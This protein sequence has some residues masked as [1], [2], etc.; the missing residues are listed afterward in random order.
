MKPHEPVWGAE[1]EALETFFDSRRDNLPDSVKMGHS[2]IVNVPLFIES[3]LERVKAHNGNPTFK[4][5]LDR[6]TGLKE[7]LLTADIQRDTTTPG[8]KDCAA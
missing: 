8:S 3:H 6:L 5:Y 1:I 4:P 7:I 2:V